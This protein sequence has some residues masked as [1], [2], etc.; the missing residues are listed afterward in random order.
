MGGLS[1]KRPGAEVE[2][3]LRAMGSQ[4]C[5]STWGMTGQRWGFRSPFCFREVWKR[6]AGRPDWGRRG[7]KRMAA[8]ENYGSGDGVYQQR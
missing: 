5:V 6:P 2:L 4:L 3:E 1:G 8:C 7:E